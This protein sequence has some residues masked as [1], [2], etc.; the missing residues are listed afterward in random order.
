MSADG[1]GGKTSGAFHLLGGKAPEMIL[2]PSPRR[3]RAFFG[4]EAVVDSRRAYLLHQRGSLPAYYFPRDDVR[5]DLLAPTSHTSHCPIRGDAR[6]WSLKVGD[7]EVENA[8]WNYPDPREDAPDVSD[9]LSFYWDSM[10]RWFEEEEEVFVHPRDPYHRIDVLESSRHVEVRWEGTLLAESRRPVLLFETGLPVRFYLP[11]LDVRTDLMESS[12][13]RT[14]CPYKGRTSA[15]WSAGGHGGEDG[16]GDLAWCY[17]F[18]LEGVRKIAGRIAFYQERV[19][20]LVD[21]EPQ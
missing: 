6:Y 13:T 8:V 17:E 20:V 18:P 15:Y 7:R 19:D 10:D 5:E 16:E 21:G 2:E 12:D 3:V 11:K 1:A 9:L 14:E 4:G